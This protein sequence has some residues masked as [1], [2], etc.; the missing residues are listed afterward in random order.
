MIIDLSEEENFDYDV[1][2]EIEKLFPNAEFLVCEIEHYISGKKSFTYECLLFENISEWL[3]DFIQ[4]QDCKNGCQWDTET[5]EFTVNGSCW[6]YRNSGN[7][8]DMDTVT[9]R[10]KQADRFID[11]DDYSSFSEYYCDCKELYLGL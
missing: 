3:D 11:C 10:F 8:G 5:H 2:G 7:Y 6:Y 9:V 4:R 1:V